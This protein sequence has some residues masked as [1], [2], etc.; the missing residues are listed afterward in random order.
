MAAS[1]YWKHFGLNSAPFP[2]TPTDDAFYSGG[3]RKATVDATLHVLRDESGIVK[4]VGEAGTGK[5]T[6]C[7]Q[8]T[9]ELGDRYTVVYTCDPSLGG[10]QTWFALA[11]ALRLAVDR[12][13]ARDAAARVR[14]RIAELHGAGAP[15]LLLVDEAHALP[16][17]TREQFRL[18]AQHGAD[19]ERMRIVLL[20]PDELDHDLALPAM[21]ALR[22]RIAHSIRLKRLKLADIDEY[23]HFRMKSAGWSGAP[24]FNANA[25]R[26]I[27]R[28]SAGIPRRINVIADK[29]LLSAAMDRRHQVGARD[30][31][32]AADEIK[33]SRRRTGAPQWSLA[34]A[35]FAGGIA[36]AVA[37]GALAW[38]MLRPD[39]SV[40]HAAASSSLEAPGLA[41][42]SDAAPAAPATAPQSAVATV[43]PSSSTPTAVPAASPP[44]VAAP[45]GNGVAP[46]DPADLGVVPLSLGDLPAPR[47][48]QDIGPAPTGSN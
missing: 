19:G 31:A 8:L 21:D 17:E 10:D 9:R 11:D 6:L 16:G 25:V 24:V 37:I 30:V 26:A 41:R 4:V 33:L 2:V 14:A 34:G 20:G 18:L 45:S 43:T 3:T 35:A 7:R 46:R 15:V 44:V 22:T 36:V 42:S 23:L 40:P 48:V 32:A 29:A 12:A 28:L 13:D 27:A 38:Q 47:F 5:T 1:L 39:A